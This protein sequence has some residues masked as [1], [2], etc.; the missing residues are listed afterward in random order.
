[1]KDGY[2]V[3]IKD[4]A[5]FISPKVTG[6]EHRYN[7]NYFTNMVRQDVQINS[8]THKVPKSWL[9]HTPN[10]PIPSD[11]SKLQVQKQQIFVRHVSR[12]VVVWRIRSQLK[13][14]VGPAMQ[15]LNQIYNLSIQNMY[16]IDELYQI[17]KINSN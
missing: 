12:N 17:E 9:Q 3:N 16:Q 2:K 6:P 8:M 7:E 14:S 1:M 4:D 10:P 11:Q 13:Q 15:L 5:V